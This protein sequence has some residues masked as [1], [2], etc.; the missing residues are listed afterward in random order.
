MINPITLLP[1]HS[2]SDSLYICFTYTGFAFSVFFSIK[3]NKII[4]ALR[5]ERGGWTNTVGPPFG[6]LS[7]FTVLPPIFRSMIEVLHLEY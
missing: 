4:S 7:Y 6:H 2:S 3:Q 5:I 1:T